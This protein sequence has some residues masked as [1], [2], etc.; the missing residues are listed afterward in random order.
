VGTLIAAAEFD[1]GGWAVR[2]GSG[3]LGTA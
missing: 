3:L 2:Y 1:A